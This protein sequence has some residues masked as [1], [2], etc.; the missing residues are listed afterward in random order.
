MRGRHNGFSV[1]AAW[2]PHPRPAPLPV[3]AL[4]HQAL[5]TQPLEVDSGAGFFGTLRR[6]DVI[7]SD[8]KQLIS[9]SLQSAGIEI[10]VSGQRW[11]KH[12]TCA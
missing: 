7:R 3:A 1:C 12:D 5:Y 9:S 6:L 11:C 8:C 4:A 2:R 10:L